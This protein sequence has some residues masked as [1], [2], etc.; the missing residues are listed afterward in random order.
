MANSLQIFDFLQFS[1]QLINS[2]IRISQFP[3]QFFDSLNMFITALFIFYF[4]IRPFF[5]LF[6]FWESV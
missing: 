5:S 3:S 2:H 1:R 6:Y 4:S